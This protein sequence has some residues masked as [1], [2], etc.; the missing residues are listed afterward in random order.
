M[1][2][3]I[4][5]LIVLL[6]ASGCAGNPRQ[7]YTTTIEAALEADRLT[8]EQWIVPSGQTIRLHLVNRSGQDAD[9]TL[10][11]RPVTPPF[12]SA[13]EPNVWFSQ[14]L[15]AGQEANVEFAAPAAPGE[16]N[17]VCMRAFCDRERI[18]ATLLVVIPEP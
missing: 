9:W 10:M 12:D 8:P 7:E 18:R 16:Y 2:K 17:V 11:A 5:I 6:L 4:L 3:A 14:P 1:H 15:A 13:D